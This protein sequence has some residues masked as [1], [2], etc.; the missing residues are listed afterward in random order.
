MQRNVTRMQNNLRSGESGI[1]R[2]CIGMQWIIM[3]KL[4]MSYEKNYNRNEIEEIKNKN[5]H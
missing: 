3:E 1:E 4:G 5:E 2:N